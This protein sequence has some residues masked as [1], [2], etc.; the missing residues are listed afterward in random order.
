M[1]SVMPDSYAENE[2]NV[3]ASYEVL[4][5][6][7][8]AVFLIGS[9]D[10]VIYVNEELVQLLGLDK[11][12][13]LGHPYTLLFG[14]IA[15]LSDSTR[16]TLNSLIASR[17]RLEHLPC[18]PV[19]VFKP[20]LRRFQ[21]EMFPLK[22]I[23]PDLVWGG[24]I[25]DVTQDYLQSSQDNRVLLTLS[26]ELRSLLV[27]AMGYITV[28]ANNHLQWSEDECQEMLRASKENAEQAVQL[29]ENMRDIS[30]L[31]LNELQLDQRPTDLKRL[32]NYTMQ[33]L[34]DEFPD[35]RLDLDLPADLPMVQVDSI[36]MSRAL[37]HLFRSIIKLS[38]DNTI[39][40]Q[41]QQASQK[42]LID[43]PYQGISL[44]KPLPGNSYHAKDH[45]R[46][47]DPAH[48]MQLSLNIA[49][50]LIQAHGGTFWAE[51]STGP[52]MVVHIVLPL[53]GAT[54]DRTHPSEHPDQRPASPQG[55]AQAAHSP[56]KILIVEDD[57]QLARLLKSQLELG[58][59]R[60]LGA[61]EGKLAI[62]LAAIE[63]PDLVL[64]DVY[65]PDSNGFDIC[66]QLREFTT[67]PI[68]A[69]TGSANSEDMVR[70]LGVGADDYISKPVCAKELLARIQANLRRSYLSDVHDKS[71]AETI[72][73]LGK[74]EIDFEQRSVTLAGEPVDLTPVEY[75][76]LYYL[77]VN[78]GRVLTHDQ[79][80]SKV[81]G[82]MYRQE[83]QYLW[84]NISRLRAKIEDDPRN[85]KY[86]LTERGVG[87]FI[88]AP[89][90]PPS[91]RA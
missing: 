40:I 34:V 84:V 22:R 53:N 42:V 66:R 55:E 17:E 64:L 57:P 11:Y 30:K 68:L 89:E 91:L 43:I 48:K 46:D 78:A 77:A 28:L 74:L 9:D 36:R 85:P 5:N 80:V 61:A 50:S 2:S 62:E 3:L 60:T 49:Q 35:L 54:A 39:Q 10:R 76:L 27:C 29:L 87:Y 7:N 47:L 21:V 44:S 69:I 6:V 18:T 72:F 19:T 14:Q 51:S 26:E 8:E 38:F 58:G 59:Y 45:D 12:A 67:A 16:Q 15:A 52:S 37:Q 25:R 83:T 82:S 13:T 88:S 79:L 86:I 73:K 33:N 20:V 23:G 90:D 32:L 24:F 63:V 75:K 70:L 71:R 65:L 4:L 56:A 41:V 1:V 31:K 81:W